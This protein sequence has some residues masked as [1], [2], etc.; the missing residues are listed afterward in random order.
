MILKNKARKP[1]DIEKFVGKLFK[2]MIHRSFL[3]LK[4]IYDFV[5]YSQLF[6]HLYFKI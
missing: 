4:D 1:E 3:I 6:V 2:T 5:R